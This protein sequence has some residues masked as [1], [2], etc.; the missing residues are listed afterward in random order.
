MA[1]RARIKFS[2]KTKASVAESCALAYRS[3]KLHCYRIASNAGMLHAENA[4]ARDLLTPLEGRQFA[5]FML[6]RIR[7]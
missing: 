2:V 3:S 6:K 1:S 7:H 4:M 5:E